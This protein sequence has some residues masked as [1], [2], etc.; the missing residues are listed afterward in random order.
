MIVSWNWLKEYVD[1]DMSL[2]ELT[3]RLTMTGLNLEG[4]EHPDDDVAIDL[5][6]TSNRPDC[7][8]HIGVAREISV[9][10]D[11]ELRIPETAPKAT[12]PT[13]SEATSVDI[14]CEDLC[15]R[16]H[17]RVI[18]G[19]KVGPS[20]QWLI[21]RLVEAT[22][23]VRQNE[24]GEKEV[25]HYRPINNIV[26]ITN[27]VLLECGQPLHAFDYQKLNENRI[28]VRRAR[29]GETIRAIDQKDYK[30]TSDMCVIADAQRPVAI[31]GVMGG[32][33][34]EIS[35][36]TVDVLI[37]TAEFEPVSIRS[38]ARALRLHSESSFRFERR[39]DP[40]GVEW[41]SKRCCELILKI[42][43]GELLDGPVIAGAPPSDSR[44]AIP[45]RLAQT[46]RLLGIDVPDDESVKILTDLGLKQHGE[47]SNGVA[48]F[49]PPS[50]R[51]DLTREIDLIE[52]IAR[53]HGYEKI[54]DDAPV[55]LGLSD[56]A[57]R[58]RVL[59]SVRNALIASGF[60]EAITLSFV[61][62]KLY[63]LF[64]PHGDLP[65]VSV[66]HSSRKDVNLLR[67]SLI[68]SLLQ[69][70][71]ENEKHGTFNAQLFE[72]ASVFLGCAPGDPTAEPKM[73]S[74]VSGMSFAGVRGV[75]ESVADAVNHDARIT[76][77]PCDLPQF[78]QGRGAEILLDDRPWGWLGELSRETTDRLDLRDAVVVAELRIQPLLEAANLIPQ[79][80]DIPK[81]PGATRDLNFLLDEGTSW[82]ELE[83]VVRTAAGE[84]LESVSF[85]D[86]YRGEHIPADKKSYV[87]SIDYRSPERTLKAEEV[88]AVQ[89]ELITACQNQLGA[90][91]R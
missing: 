81:H 85:S 8:G 57:R 11:T 17:A 62:Q 19:V 18:R 80:H 60:F 33:D 45:L 20:P 84:L 32:L 38:T 55:P 7:L 46:S 15:P 6:V 4:I 51:R 2:D 77:R 13:A 12:G 90:T 71:R 70:R 1:L 14:E 50:W 79:F 29:D 39:V 89:Q 21:D 28:V 54:P 5:E 63:D 44:P 78:A 49:E 25:V 69:W 68:P 24:Q 61:N 34:T 36:D 48:R 67:Q 52:E 53:I 88:E 64:T 82:Q 22:W 9:L 23:H 27:Y 87:L 73:L 26:D 40:A 16:Y 43:G 65:P 76:T 86:Q 42:A 83:S 72:V 58:D 91:L 74:L 47:L 41:A 10:F 59:D 75:V 35:D 31:A 37:E 30:L 3:D 56:R 66:D